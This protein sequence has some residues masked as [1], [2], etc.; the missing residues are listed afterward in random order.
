M[1]KSTARDGILISHKVD[2]RANNIIN[3]R[4]KQ[5]YFTTKWAIHQEEKAYHVPRIID[6]N[7][8]LFSIF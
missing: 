5:V 8:Q 6:L 4:D 7:A 3:T 1:S 2:F